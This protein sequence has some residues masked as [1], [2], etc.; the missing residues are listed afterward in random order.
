VLTVDQGADSNRFTFARSGAPIHE[1][2]IMRKMVQGV[3]NVSKVP[4]NSG[5]GD[6]L[7]EGSR[8]R[9]SVEAWPEEPSDQWQ[10]LHLLTKAA[11]LVRGSRPSRK[12]ARNPLNQ[13][14][15][16]LSLA[17]QGKR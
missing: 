10:R 14:P 8:A 6:Q 7:N 5:R 4:P 1:S 9:E 13:A 12:P 2:C 3:A 16:P 17:N 11:T 15:L